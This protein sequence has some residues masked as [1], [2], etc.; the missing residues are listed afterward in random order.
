M[1][2]TPLRLITAAMV[3]AAAACIPLAGFA[4]EPAG[5]LKLAG[6]AGAMLALAWF[7]TVRRP[8][9]RL[10]RT[11]EGTALLLVLT[12]AG[13]V[14]SYAAIAAGL[15]LRDETY[16]AWDRALG[17]DWVAFLAFAAE[18][19]LLAQIL[20]AA[21][22]SSLIQIVTIV[23]LLGL[24]GRQLA[25]ERFLTAYAVSAL[26]VIGVSGLA[27]AIGPYVHYAPD[28][29]LMRMTAE[30]G[31]WHL[32]HF[33]AL[34]AGTFA[35][36]DLA[37]TEGLV[38]FPSFHTAL[39]VLTIWAAWGVAWLRWP[40]LALNLCVIAGTLPE[41]GHYLVDLV[42]GAAAALLAVAVASR[43][44]RPA[45]ARQPATGPAAAGMPSSMRI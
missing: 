13:A 12:A 18:R 3:A 31:V 14:M 28:P 9:P 8:D 1:L 17:F 39:A 29:A 19:P 44:C 43:T 2:A 40:A 5:F 36:F 20:I 21:Y 16:A 4:L 37:Q 35:V 7:Y 27:P 42:G 34:R 24:S 25:L 15:P 22:H 26:V 30:A 10:A 38:T 41:G 23:L 11:L 32:T 33:E 6:T 45:R